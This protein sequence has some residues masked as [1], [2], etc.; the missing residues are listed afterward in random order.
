MRRLIL[1][2]IVFGATITLAGLHYV[3]NNQFTQAA[4]ATCLRN[5]YENSSAGHTLRARLYAYG[6]KLFP[7]RSFCGNAYHQDADYRL[8]VEA[9]ILRHSGRSEAAL[10]ELL[11]HVLSSHSPATTEIIEITAALLR[12]KFTQEDLNAAL[13]RSLE[14]IR[15]SGSVEYTYLLTLDATTI[16]FVYFQGLDSTPV[17]MVRDSHFFAVAH[18]RPWPD[19]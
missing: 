19:A 7:L 3:P 1:L 15:P 2:L 13:D 12:E 9:N 17:G 18:G 5:A 8:V 6:A 16:P 14:T 11:P 10:E 4:H